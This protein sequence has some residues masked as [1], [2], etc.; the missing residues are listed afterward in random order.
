LATPDEIRAKGRQVL[1]ALRR[2]V[3]V[4]EESL[5]QG[6]VDDRPAVKPV[7]PVP[8]DGAASMTITTPRAIS[9]ARHSET[10]KPK[11]SGTYLFDDDE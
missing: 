2:A 11:R 3:A 1:D 6:S 7:P 10:T 8:D 5:V 9:S 4:L